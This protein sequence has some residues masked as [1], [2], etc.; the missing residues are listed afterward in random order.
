MPSLRAQNTNAPADDLQRL[1][2]DRKIAQQLQELTRRGRSGNL[3]EIRDMLQ[4]LREANP[5]LMVPDRTRTYRPLH[6]DLTE[7][8]QAFSPQLQAELL[9]DAGA[10]PHALQLAFEDRGPAGLLAFLH[11]YAGTT[12]S[13]KA[14]LLLAAIHRDRGHRQATL[15]WLAPVLHADAP[16]NLRTVALAWRDELNAGITPQTDLDT[17]PDAALEQDR[18]DGDEPDEV[19]AEQQTQK[20]AAV[21]ADQPQADLAAPIAADVASPARPMPDK[22]TSTDPESAWSTFLHTPAWQ[23][24]L[25]LS[26]A[27]RRASKDLVRLLANQGD[28]RAIAWTVNEPIID[29]EAIY[30][31]SSGG[32]LACDRT[33]GKVLWTRLLDREPDVRRGLGRGLEFNDGGGQP[34]VEIEQLQN[35]RDVL[36][37]HRDEITNRMTADASRLFVICETGESAGTGVDFSE[38]FRMFQGRRDLVSRSLRELVAIE[39]ATGRRL[40]SAGGA[41]ME[42]RFGNEL[43]LAWFAGPPIVS[44]MEL[45]GVVE[46]DDAHWLVCLRAETGEI[47]WKLMLAYPETSINQDPY[48]QLVSSRPVVA[49]GMIWTNT[50]DGWLIAI[51]ELTRTVVWSRS[52]I[53]KPAEFSRIRNMRGAAIQTQPFRSFRESWRPESMRLLPDSL[54]VTGSENH[55]LLLINPLTGAVRR[56]ISQE[57]ATVIIDVDD[58]SVVTA[59]PNKIQRLHLKNLNVAWTTQLPTDNV[60]P[61]GPGT[62]YQDQLLIPMSDGSLQSVCYSDGKLSGTL[63][64][65][66]PAFSAGGLTHIQDDVVS[67]GVDHIA[68][69][70]RSAPAQPLEPEPV[71]QAR[72]LIETGKFADAEQ[73]LINFTPTTDQIDSVHQLLFRTSTAL[74]LDDPSRRTQHLQDAARYA[75]RTQDKAI[76]QILTLKT[77]PEI[78]SDQVVEFLK[79]PQSVLN[80]ELP[81]FEELKT[82]LLSPV[83]DGPLGAQVSGKGIPFAV[84]RPLR[85]ALLSLLE[86]KLTD[87]TAS[88]SETWISVLRQISDID[89][90]SLSQPSALVRDELLNRAE[91]AI[92]A[93]RMTESTL[94]LLLQAQHFTTAFRSDD[95]ADPAL[96]AAAEQSRLRLTSLV[97]RFEKALTA[98]SARTDVPLRPHPAA[99]NLLAVLRIESLATPVVAAVL[100]TPNEVLAQQWSAWKDQS[101]TLIP[102]N[103]V[104]A[105]TMP[106][107]NERALSPR[108]LDDRFLSGWRWSTIREPS[109]LAV[110][111]LLQPEQ[112]LCTIDGGMFDALSF[113]NNGTVVRYGSIV[114]VQN[115]MGLSAVSVID[116][117]VLWSRRIPNQT[118][119]VLWNMLSEMR[120]FD[121]FYAGHHAW[122]IVF[123]QGL[124]ICGGNERWVCVQSPSRVEMIDLL[125][126]R[127]LWSCQ[128]ES[129]NQLVFAT[130]SSVFLRPFD[131]ERDLSNDGDASEICLNR[132]DGTLKETRISQEQLRHTILA[133]GDE[134]VIWKPVSSRKGSPSLNWVN[135]ETGEERHNLTLTDMQTCQFLDV[136]TLVSVTK[137]NTF[138]VIDLPTAAKQIVELNANLK[139]DTDDSSSE[140]H[141]K[142]FVVTDPANY[143]VFPLPDRQAVQLQVMVGSSGD[144]SLFP[145]QKELRAIDRISGNTRW[146]WTADQNKTDEQEADKST[147]AWFDPSADPV[148]LL[149]TTSARKNNPN[150]P[151]RIVIP[152]LIL[153]GE[154]KTTITGLSR[155]SGTKLFD[156][157]VLSRFPVPSLQFKITPQQHLDLQAFGNRVR[158]V[159]AAVANPDGKPNAV[160]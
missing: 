134:L 15:Y 114:L 157:D 63:P 85:H 127:N 125:T 126:G 75:T 101:Y 109:V 91:A 118:S 32:L 152:G 133:V 2:S 37:L 46:Q 138:E 68:L 111:S 143:Y 19:A 23:Q 64:G 17:G 102:V 124:R 14:H 116:Q 66:R 84:T 27:E 76:V 69:Y 89:V 39:K 10:T 59:G 151:P 147:A 88:D 83:V 22:A 12:E 122:Q 90:L 149:V 52:M 5:S 131:T 148:L 117:S 155:M 26:S 48:R 156:Y 98:E 61:T 99:L 146:I 137:N 7:R 3:A 55:Q 30:V 129:T 105:S 70:S 21:E 93:G 97:D 41:P 130:E 74:A 141:G 144:L 94:H 139:G 81:D 16:G 154:R 9:K 34:V 8:I 158:F 51:D 78:T 33:S 100:P 50:S 145:I 80:T 56:R 123:G 128:T 44:G 28:Q 13:L 1:P 4:K 40:W 86:E 140:G 119:N 45:Y 132:I 25:H 79:A 36:E 53:Q 95:S 108:S 106:Q 11:R 135:A 31:R 43:S 136:R 49:D 77:Q 58:E 120:L 113:G 96:A 72:F 159:P 60:A 115:S 65:F 20:V 29:P 62:R 67:Y 47:V 92:E 87:L 153:P 104:A 107:N 142:F 121:S 57:N 54:L 103:P 18:N 24:K 35:S 160:D 112:P 82:R 6:R 73:V 71:E 42:E 38:P 110:R 150:R